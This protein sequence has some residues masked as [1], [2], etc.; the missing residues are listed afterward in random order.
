MP[1]QS[2]TT[3][4][5]QLPVPDA[6][7]ESRQNAASCPVPDAVTVSRQ[8][9]AS[10]PVPDAI[11]SLYDRTPPHAPR[12]MPFTEVSATERSSPVRMPL[13]KSLRPRAAPHAA[14]VHYR[15]LYDRTIPCPVP[16]H[17]RSLYDRT[18]P[19]A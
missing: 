9:A 5:A 13:H 3:R 12:M 19:R 15:S 11:T 17:Y 7:T 10:C 4:P 14:P 6:I 16:C 2:L 8:N 18:P 1:L